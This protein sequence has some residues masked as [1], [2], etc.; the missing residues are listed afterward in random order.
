MFTQVVLGECG[1]RLWVAHHR[2]LRTHGV[3]GDAEHGDLFDRGVPVGHILYFDRG[4]VFAAPDDDFLDPAGDVEEVIVV[5]V[6][7]IACAKIDDVDSVQSAIN[8][9]QRDASSQT[10]QAPLSMRSK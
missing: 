6:A 3:V 1:V 4:D 8:A 5:E 7:E 10:A 9:L 2:Q